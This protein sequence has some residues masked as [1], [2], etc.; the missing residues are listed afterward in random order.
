M[1][2]VELEDNVGFFANH[3]RTQ[4]TLQFSSEKEFSKNSP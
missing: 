3:L 2:N 1:K 4:N